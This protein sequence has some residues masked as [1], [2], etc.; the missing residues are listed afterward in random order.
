M[1]CARPAVPPPRRVCSLSFYRV[2]FRSPGK[3]RI[4]GDAILDCTLELVS[5]PGK[6]EE[7]IEM[8]GVID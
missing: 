8:N 5:V 4:P 7:I 2:L 1:T 3:P 6:D